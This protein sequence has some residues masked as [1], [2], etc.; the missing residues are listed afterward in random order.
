MRTLVSP[1]YIATINGVAVRF[2]KGP[3]AEPEYPWHAADDLFMACSLSRDHR[4][5][6][7]RATQE[8][9]GNVIR[10]VA[11]SKGVVT[12]APHYVAQGFLAA[13]VETRGVPMRI[14]TAY[15]RAAA[16]AMDLLVGDL[17]P[18]ASLGFVIAAVKNT[19]G[20]GS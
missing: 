6:F 10:T 20:D 12:I 19:L 3:G 15:T 16:K 17:G 18:Q 1:I 4:R 2:F 7:L 8:I 13:V 9:P 14:E 5:F 11:T